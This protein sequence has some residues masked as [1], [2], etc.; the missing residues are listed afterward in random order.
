MI[1]KLIFVKYIILPFFNDILEDF[2]GCNLKQI[3]KLKKYAYIFLDE[4]EAHACSVFSIETNDDKV[5][6]GE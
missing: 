2:L 5:Y 1:K 6:Q 4:D 3:L